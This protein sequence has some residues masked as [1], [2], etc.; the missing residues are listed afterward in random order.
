M[1]EIF[2]FNRASYYFYLL[3]L[4]TQ[5]RGVCTAVLSSEKLEENHA[6]S[7]RRKLA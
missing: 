3:N 4:A 6:L 5:T 1:F 7:I 2:R